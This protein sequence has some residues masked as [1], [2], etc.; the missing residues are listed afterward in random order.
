MFD[1]RLSFYYSY[2]NFNP[3]MMLLLKL[4]LI[5]G[6]QTMS[7]SMDKGKKDAKKKP[8]KSVKEKK[9]AKKLKK[10]GKV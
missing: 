8:V 10:A 1:E 7:K 3:A 4:K 9:E 2:D 5:F 6:G